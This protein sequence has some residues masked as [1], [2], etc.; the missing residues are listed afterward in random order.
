MA[1]TKFTEQLTPTTDRNGNWNLP[2]S[3]SNRSRAR[4]QRCSKRTGRQA[5]PHIKND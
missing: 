3:S 2:A 1:L 5:G 4:P